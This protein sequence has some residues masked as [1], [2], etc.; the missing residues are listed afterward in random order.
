MLPISNP[1]NLVIYGS[2]MPPLLRLAAALRAASLVAI[3]ATYVVLRLT[4]RTALRQTLRPR[5]DAPA[6]T[7]RR[8]VA[9]V[10]IA[11]TAVVLLTASALDMQLGLPTCIAGALTAI[12]RADRSTRASPMAGA[13]GHSWG[14]LPLVAGLFV[15][16]EALDRTGA[17][18]AARRSRMRRVVHPA[19]AGGLGQRRSPR[20]RATS[21]NNL[22]AG[23]IAG[24]RRAD[25][26]SLPSR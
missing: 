17:D 10:G 24:Q 1:A 15:L 22:P 6:L 20:S 26:A 12:V 14:V 2:H 13:E 16:V 21:I 9:A 23:L 4:Q 7:A 18:P 25:R 5:C 19:A 3:V 11:A 8:P